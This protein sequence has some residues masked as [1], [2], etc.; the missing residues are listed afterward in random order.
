MV[1]DKNYE[2]PQ[3]L[4]DKIG[5]IEGI[6]SIMDSVFKA[7]MEDEGLAKFYREKNI[8]ETKKKYAY[9]IAG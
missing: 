6:Q 8:N 5:M 9:F 3:T 4:F 1:Y 7:I 2:E